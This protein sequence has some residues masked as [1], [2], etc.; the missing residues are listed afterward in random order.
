MD[1]TAALATMP[2]APPPPGQVTNFVDPPSR[3]AAIIGVS[4][5]MMVLTLL[6]VSLRLY[7]TFRITRSRGLEDCKCFSDRPQVKL[8]SRR[9]LSTGNGNLRRSLWI[10]LLIDSSYFRFFHSLTV[11]SPSSVSSA[12]PMHS[13]A[14]SYQADHSASESCCKTPMGCTRNMVYRRLLEGL[15]IQSPLLS[16]EAL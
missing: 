6:F 12:T 7:S 3:Q 10:A 2:A 13:S 9:S 1:P 8:T 5:M 14:E 11:V 16:A 15:N 4:A